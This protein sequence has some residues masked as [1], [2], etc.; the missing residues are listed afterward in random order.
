MSPARPGM[1]DRRAPDLTPL[2]PASPT[3]GA[4]R[5]RDRRES[6]GYRGLEFVLPSR[7]HVPSATHHRVIVLFHRSYFGVHHIG[8]FEKLRFRC[9]GHET[10]DR[11]SG[12][13]QLVSERN[14]SW[15]TRTA[16][17]TTTF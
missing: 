9:S 5:L 4:A 10:C 2:S 16:R 12:F 15:G 13:L 3:A 17:T 14:V 11:H 7:H 1:S 8:A 6:R